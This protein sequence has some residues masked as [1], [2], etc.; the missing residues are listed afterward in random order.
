MTNPGFMIHYS[1]KGTS[2]SAKFP[3]EDPR[4]KDVA[5]KMQADTGMC[6]ES[7]KLLGPGIK[8]S[9]VLSQHNDESVHDVGELITIKDQVD[10]GKYYA[11]L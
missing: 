5:T 2:Y 10:L 8:G 7:L 9:L 1:F 4:V 11:G 6:N 3:E